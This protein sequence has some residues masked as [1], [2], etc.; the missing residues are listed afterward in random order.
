MSIKFVTSA[1]D[2]DAYLEGNRFVMV[3][4][5]ALWCGP[6]QA[7]KPILDQLYID[8]DQ[9]Y[10]GV[11]MVRVDLDTQRELSARYEITSVP[12]FL[13]F[14]EKQV[15]ERIKGANVPELIKQLDAFATQARE[16]DAPPRSGNGRSV[17]PTT[18]TN[19]LVKEI[20]EYI[21]KGY[22]VLNGSIH[23]G[24]FESLNVHSLYNKEIK[25]VFKLDSEFSESSVY[26]DADSQLLFY[27]PLMNISKVYSFL[28]KISN[29][30]TEEG[31][32]LDSDDLKDESQRPNLV[33][34]WLNQQSILSFDDATED[35]NAPH[36]ENID[37]TALK[38]DWYEIKVKFVRFQNVQSLNIFI[39]GDDED[40][41]TIVDKIV[42]IGVNGE[43]KEQGKIQKDED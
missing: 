31:S 1:A 14:R 19:P 38:N 7:V 5:T 30:H 12:T 3:N 29:T 21:P 34:V 26:S 6:C 2:L 20:A 16:T 24:E 28:I 37:V 22:E 8:P 36:I 32:T 10:I 33:K 40:Y 11:E 9:K 4:F 23:F 41:H 35:S 18:T 27:V 43:S 15:V 42:I 13:F 39:D 17:N 25:E